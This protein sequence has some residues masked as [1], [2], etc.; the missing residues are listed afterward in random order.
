MSGRALLCTTD[1]AGRTGVRS[2][3]ISSQYAIAASRAR[4]PMIGRN[5]NGGLVITSSPLRPEPVV[6][7]KR[8]ALADET[9][10]GVDGD[11]RDED[12][13]GD[14]GGVGVGGPCSVKVAHGLGG[15]LTHSRCTPT[16]SP[17]N[18]VTT[19]VKLPLESVTTLAATCAC[20]SQY[21]LMDWPAQN[22][23]PLTVMFVLGPPAAVSRSIWAPIGVGVGVGVDPVGGELVGP[24]VGVVLR[25]ASTNHAGTM[26]RTFSDLTR[27]PKGTSDRRPG[28]RPG[29]GRLGKSPPRI[30]HTAEPAAQ[31]LHLG[32]VEQPVERSGELS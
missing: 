22:A 25:A 29:G 14:D 18:G 23:D 16:L 2:T 15:M 17:G 4:R 21:R 6:S 12:G 31:H 5:T 26:T 1:A 7:V 28:D 27:K 20:V 30:H 19:F 32:R 13:D 11:A 3:R 10:D 24:G 8:D 9:G